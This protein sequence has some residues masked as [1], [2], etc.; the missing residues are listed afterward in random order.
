MTLLCCN[1]NTIRDDE[2]NLYAQLLPAFMKA[3][4]M[5]Y[6]QIEDQKCRLAARLMLL[7]SMRKTGMATLIHQ[8]RKEPEGKPYINGWK[9]FNISHS[10]NMVVLGYDQQPLGLDI[11]KKTV[12]NHEELLHC[13]HPRERAFIRNATD[14]EDAFFTVWVAKEAFVKA[15]GVGIIND[16]HNY[17]CLQNPLQYRGK[18][19]YFHNW[20]LHPGYAF[21]LCCPHKESSMAII[22]FQPSKMLRYNAT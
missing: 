14:K 7:E 4:I 11:E 12:I 2:V 17:N 19:W 16:L 15:T 13:F 1:T 22:D 10:G 9:A 18:Q 21:C 8:W 5:R 3:D 20:T 6:N